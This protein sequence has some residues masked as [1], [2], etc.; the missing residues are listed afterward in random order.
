M[1]IEDNGCPWVKC[2]SMSLST[3]AGA[4]TGLIDKEDYLEVAYMAVRYLSRVLKENGLKA[5]NLRF[6]I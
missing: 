4:S 5:E 1:I 2:L 3:L 6:G